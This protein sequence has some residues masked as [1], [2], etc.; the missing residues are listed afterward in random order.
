MMSLLSGAQPSPESHSDPRLRQGTG[1]LGMCHE[2]Q[3]FPSPQRCSDEM[4]ALEKPNRTHPQLWSESDQQV[5]GPS[6]Q[7][8][9]MR[10]SA[11][12]GEDPEL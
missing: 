11:W 3:K 6:T 2:F 8:G 12:W 4:G 10:Q 5:F 1:A 7:E 9:P